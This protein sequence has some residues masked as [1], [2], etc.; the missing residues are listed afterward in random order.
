MWKMSCNV[1]NLP[2]ATE[3][4]G[5]PDSTVL[6]WNSNLIFYLIHLST[7]KKK[8][9]EP[10][11]SFWKS[12]VRMWQRY[13]VPQHL[14]IY[15]IQPYEKTTNSELCPRNTVLSDC[16]P[17]SF[18]QAFYCKYKCWIE[19]VTSPPE[20]QKTLYNCLS[21]RG[22]VLQSEVWYIQPT[23]QAWSQWMNGWESI[24]F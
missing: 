1:W 13:C 10:E 6:Q 8:S 2:T 15:I 4:L 5:Y 3:L 21:G 16:T 24:Y 19:T 14:N 11:M 18:T 23:Y 9:E 7:K 17:P 20:L 12:W 22:V